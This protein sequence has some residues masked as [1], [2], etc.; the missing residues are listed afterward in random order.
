MAASFL[1][2]LLAP[3]W[4]AQILTGARSFLDNP[5]IGSQ[6]LNEQ[7]LHIWRV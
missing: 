1:R 3:V 6:R 7:G 4:A 2:P 5:L